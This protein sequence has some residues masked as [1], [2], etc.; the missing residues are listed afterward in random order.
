MRF[1]LPLSPR[2][3]RESVVPMIN[4]VFL[5]LIFF[6]MSAQIAPPDPF[7]LT[8]AES[9]GAPSDPQP[10]TVYMSSTGA[11]AFEGLS[12]DAALAAASARPALALRADTATPAADL[13]RVLARLAALGATEVQLIAGARP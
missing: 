1:A 12:G 8:L 4:V 3:P 11:L 9:A 2:R 7:E 5:L 13:A 6:L 10:G